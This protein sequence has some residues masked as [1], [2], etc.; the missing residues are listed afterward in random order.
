MNKYQSGA[1]PK[2]HADGVPVFCAHDAI[3]DAAALVP[4]PKNPNNHPDSQ[5]Q[6]LG[7]IIRSAGWRQPITVS[8][9]SGFI[10]KGHGR[11]AAALLEG[12][13]EVPVD[14]Q[15]YASEAEEYADL[16]A[17]NRLAELA[18]LDQKMLA[19]I[20][21]EIDTDEIPMELTG[22]TDDQ[23]QEIMDALS[24]ALNNEVTETEEMPELPED[25]EIITQPGDLWIL[26]RHRLMCGDS[27]D[28][29]AVKSL[30][31]E[32]KVDMVFTDPPYALF[33]NS[34]G[35]VGVGDDKMIMP[36]F[37]EIGAA[38]QRALKPMGHAYVCHD[39]QTSATIRNAFDGLTPKN[40]IVWRKAEAGGLGSFYTKIYELIWLFANEPETG[41]LGKNK[42]HARTI[43]GVANIWDVSVVQARER[44][45]N[46]QKPVKV[47][48]IAVEN[49]SDEGE[50]VL[51]LFGGSGTT[52]IACEQLGRS[53]YM[54]ELEPKY[55]DVIVRRYI[56]TTGDTAG[57]RLI[58]DGKEM[59][60]EHFESMLE[61]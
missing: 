28:P 1:D 22:Y 8:T 13:K 18:D 50:N 57:V 30:L 31:G 59:D 42:L 32:Q 24:E 33:G 46:A 53:C 40:L 35:V 44:D 58:R 9:R 14:Y 55:N 21:A 56:R 11:L 17:D 5:V 6:L 27:T 12:M 26:G 60:R 38:I 16:I 2:A 54:M 37:R 25:D 3:V 48:A 41:I 49:S 34:T 39:W 47:V 20:F 45:H 19:E 15:A 36:F 29:S 4:N 10:V 7:R 43:N 61:E 52:L 51:D 23:A